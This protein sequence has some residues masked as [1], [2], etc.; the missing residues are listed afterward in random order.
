MAS[1]EELITMPLVLELS[2]ELLVELDSYM[3]SR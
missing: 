1:D 3:P 2:S